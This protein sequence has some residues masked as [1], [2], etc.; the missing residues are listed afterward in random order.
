[1]QPRIMK[2]QVTFDEFYEIVRED[3]KADLIDGV[4]HLASPE[5]LEGN[6]LV[7]WTLVVVRVFVRR[8]NLGHVYHERVAF[9]LAKHQ[10][11]EPDIA[12]VRKDRL[13]LAKSGYFNGPPDV[14]FEF[15]SPESVERDYEI[16]RLKYQE[17]GVLEYWI[18]DEHLQTVQL[19]RLGTDGLYM[20]AE[21][22]DGRFESR[23]I[24]GFHLRPEWL[25]QSP[26]P[27]ELQT[28]LD[29]LASVSP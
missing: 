8:R 7:G 25:W 5:S 17:A 14:A 21:P 9:R 28:V 1:M 13:H 12:F 19:L 29:M 27:D 15:V 10:S 26:L 16:K 24:A 6:D 22:V 11:P 20:K 23:A 3:Q 2:H 4:I 18:I